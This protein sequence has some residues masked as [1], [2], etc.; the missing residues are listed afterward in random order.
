MRTRRLSGHKKQQLDAVRNEINVTP[1]VDV[2]LVLLII[3][4]VISQLMVRGKAVP[5][6]PKT[7]Y[8][9][10]EKDKLQPVISIDPDGIMFFDKDK[11]GP[12]SDDTLALLGQRVQQAW[13]APKSPEAPGHVYL[14]AASELTF[15]QVLPVIKYFNESELGIQSIELAT[16][17]IKEK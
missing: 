13:A 10:E 17:E 12:I 1:L 11:L 3:F 16:N 7:R 8:H 2:V 4:M 6:L 15:K 9:S 14:K 5:S